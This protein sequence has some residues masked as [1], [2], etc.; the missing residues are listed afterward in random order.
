VRT[1]STRAAVP[2]AAKP[3]T[4]LRGAQ[5]RGPARTGRPACPPRRGQASL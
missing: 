4:W 1:R 5:R 3:P 2:I